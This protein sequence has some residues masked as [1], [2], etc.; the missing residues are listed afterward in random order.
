MS[1]KKQRLKVAKLYEKVSNC[2]QDYLHKC[3]YSLIK[4]YDVIC[5]E[6]LNVVGMLKNHKLAK[7]I[8]DVSWGSFIAMLTYKAAWNNKQ[9]VKIDRFFPSSQTCNV[10]GY[11]NSE[12]KKLENKRMGVSFLWYTS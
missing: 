10:C 4:S 1:T 7:S 6:D 5:I 3:S 2:R 11:H 8:A 9:V 12:T